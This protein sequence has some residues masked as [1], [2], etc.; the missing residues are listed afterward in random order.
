VDNSPCRQRRRKNPKR[1]V[2]AL[3]RILVNK[4]GGETVGEAAPAVFSSPPQSVSQICKF[5]LTNMR[6]H[7]DQLIETV[8]QYFCQ[9]ILENRRS[10]RG[11]S[12]V[13]IFGFGSM[14]VH[15]IF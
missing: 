1:G 13:V 7:L 9:K 15:I 5:S 8:I 4:S 6:N 2:W 11:W 14:T 12:F 3:Q 10:M